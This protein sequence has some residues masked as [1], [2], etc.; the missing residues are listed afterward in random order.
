MVLKRLY[1]ELNKIYVYK[2]KQVVLYLRH[3]CFLIDA[4]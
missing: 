1:D 4:V 2:R 3:T